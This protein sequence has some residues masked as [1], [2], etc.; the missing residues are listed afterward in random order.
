MT[1][2]IMSYSYHAMMLSIEVVFSCISDIGI[3]WYNSQGVECTQGLLH[4]N[5]TYPQGKQL[6]LSLAVFTVLKL[7]T[8]LSVYGTSVQTMYENEQVAINR[9]LCMFEQ[10]TVH[11]SLF[12]Q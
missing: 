4:V 11:P 2:S 1:C 3:Q 5:T 12:V 8:S 9:L 6:S 10:Q 7:D